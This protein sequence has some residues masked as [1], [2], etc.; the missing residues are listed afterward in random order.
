MPRQ[1]SDHLARF[2]TRLRQERERAGITQAELAQRIADRKGTKFDSTTITRI[3]KQIRG[4][5]LEEA[6]LAADA[7]GLPLTSLLVD[8]AESAFAESIQENLELLAQAQD[9]WRDAQARV[10]K[11]TEIVQRITEDRSLYRQ[12]GLGPEREPT[13]SHIPS[14]R[15]I[16]K[17]QS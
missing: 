6:M 8:D 4:V 3:E 2:A 1:P 11:Y 14:V 17:D 5:R 12:Q 9:D 16:P 7:L 13:Q 10:R 15:S